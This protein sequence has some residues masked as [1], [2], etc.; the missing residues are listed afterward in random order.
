MHDTQD[1]LWWCEKGVELETRFVNDVAP[2]LGIPAVINPEKAHNPYAPDLLVDGHIADLKYQGKPYFKALEQGGVDSQYAVSFNGKDYERYGLKYPEI[3]IFFWVHWE[4]T[5]RVIGGKPYSVNFMRGVWRTPFRAL[6]ALCDKAQS[7]AYRNRIG[8]KAGNA[9]D[10][11]VVD[12][13]DM[14]CVIMSNRVYN[15][16]GK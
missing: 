16:R 9:K 13:R 7:H 12:L 11:Y 1:K 5:S 6:A 4:E 8:D 14:E 15:G 10:S 3:E 2:R